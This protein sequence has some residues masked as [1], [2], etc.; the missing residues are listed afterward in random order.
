[1]TFFD[2]YALIMLFTFYTLLISKS[3]LTH[4]KGHD[5]IALGKHKKGKAKALE[6][7]F[8]LGMG[9]FTY[10]V[11]TSALNIPFIFQIE[12]LIL[13]DFLVTDIIGF[14]LLNISIILFA[15]AL[16]SFKDAW[17]IGVDHKK[18]NTLITTGVFKYTRNPTY[19]AIFLLFLGYFLS[20][21]NFFFL[22]SVLFIFFAFNH[23]IRKEEK[24]LELLFK[25]SYLDYKKHTSKYFGYKK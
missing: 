11:I 7:S 5:V 14:I 22:G 19:L 15:F 8:Y 18:T 25:E 10:L 20:Y 12:L 2:V 4:K 21:A 13:F 16:A 17:R 24:L 9:F 1:M 23:Q 6:L 3:I